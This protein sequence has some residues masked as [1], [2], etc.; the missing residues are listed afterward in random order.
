MDYEKAYKEALERAKNGKWDEYTPISRVLKEVFPV[1]AE[2]EDE[3]I[4]KEI[5]ESIKGNMSVIHK[6]KCIDWL[7]RQGEQKKTTIQEPKPKFEVGD[8]IISDKAHED[9]RIC[10][11]IEVGNGN[12]KIKSIHG[13][14]WYYEYKFFDSIYKPW[15]IEDAKNGDVLVDY[16]PFIF[17]KFDTYGRCY[18]YCGLNLYNEFMIESEGE[19]GEWT[20]HHNVHPATNEETNLLFQKM[21]EAGYEWDAEKKELKK[22]VQNLTIEMKSAEESLGIDSETYN[23]IVDDCLFGGQNPVWS[24]EDKRKLELLRSL[25][26]DAKGGSASY[27]TMFR[28]MEELDNW[29][30]SLKDRVLPQNTITDEELAYAKK[31]AYNEAL[32]KNE[33]SSDS[34]TFGDGWDAAIWYLKK[35]GCTPKKNIEWIKAKQKIIDWTV[36]FL[37][38]KGFEDEAEKLASLKQIF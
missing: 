33:Y 3:R 1:L 23:K 19:S 34:P 25:I 22:I 31:D 7:E 8:W 6:D 12:Y 36:D 18:A 26:D 13:Y 27:S 2:S 4:R 30:K 24:E 17:K 15:T 28:E 38:Y 29:L 11:I 21:R 9:Y 20:W 14:T 37:K 5:I 16:H 32:D 35:K 10:K